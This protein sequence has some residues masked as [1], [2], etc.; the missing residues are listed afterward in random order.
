M[1]TDRDETGWAECVHPVLVPQGRQQL[2]V[3][4]RLEVGDIEGVVPAANS[5]M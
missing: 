1:L 2:T 5:D 3:E 4:H